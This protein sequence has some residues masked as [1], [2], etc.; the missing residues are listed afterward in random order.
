MF[1]PCLYVL[2]WLPHMSTQ[3]HD[4]SPTP[5]SLNPLVPLLLSSDTMPVIPLS[6]TQHS[7]LH[8]CLLPYVLCWLTCSLDQVLRDGSGVQAE[9]KMD[10]AARVQLCAEA[11]PPWKCV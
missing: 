2:P 6:A 10:R 3:Q 5:L 7:S 9:Y 4:Q 11:S 1:I 8:N